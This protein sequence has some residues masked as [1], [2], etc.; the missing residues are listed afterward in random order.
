MIKSTSVFPKSRQVFLVPTSKNGEVIRWLIS[1]E[2]EIKNSSADS[3][4]STEVDQVF[5]E[6]SQDSTP[7]LN[8]IIS[9][10]LSRE[11]ISNLEE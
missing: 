10:K 1:G 5:R 11:Q 4:M 9:L 6:I 8:K 3:K 7:L 2:H